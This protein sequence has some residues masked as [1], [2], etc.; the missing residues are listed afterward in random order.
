MRRDWRRGGKRLLPRKRRN[1]VGPLCV[2]VLAAM[3]MA[4]GVGTAAKYVKQ[5]QYDLGAAEPAAFY[6]SSDVLRPESENA[7]Y[8][9][10]DWSGGIP[11]ML[12]NYEDPM[13]WSAVDITYQIECK[14][15]SIASDTG[16]GTLKGGGA[17]SATVTVTPDDGAGEV[18]VTAT[19]TAPYAKTLTGV[20]LLTPEDTGT[21]AVR[22]YAAFALMPPA[23]GSYAVQ[24]FAGSPTAE[25]ILMGG[26]S[27]RELTI[28]WPGGE[29]AADE[30]NG[31]FVIDRPTGGGY[32]S[33]GHLTLGPQESCTLLLFKSDPS[34]D[35]TV[36][37]TAIY[38]DRID[39]AANK[40][41]S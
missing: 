29:L 5:S 3:A 15:G 33:V 7:S 8:P 27:R 26:K 38:G 34:L 11:I 4:V 28:T 16:G 1:V 18:T 19:T 2:A 24:D 40:S 36:P 13:R 30:T 25:L 41:G 39:I 21:Y 6:F 23:D 10:S 17:E 12:N 32:S 9:I 20:F 22:S 14:N 31:Q 35:H 37:R